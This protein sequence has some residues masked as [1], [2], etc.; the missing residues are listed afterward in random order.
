VALAVKVFDP[1]PHIKDVSWA[2]EIVAK[3]IKMIKNKCFMLKLKIKRL[4]NI[5]KE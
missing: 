3:A 1:D 4:K 5:V 2:V